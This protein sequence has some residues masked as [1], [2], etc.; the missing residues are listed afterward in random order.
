MT[1]RLACCALTLAL[2]LPST[3]AAQGPDLRVT[4]VNL[5]FERIDSEAGLSHNTVLSILQD[6]EGFL[7]I[8][9]SDGLNRYDGHAFVTYRHDPFDTTSLSNNTVKVLIE[10]QTGTLWAGTDDGLNRFD[11]RTGRFVRYRF[12]PDTLT[13]SDKGIK[14][15]LED[16]AGRLWVGAFIPGH[17]LN[18]YDPHTDQTR[19]FN[20]SPIW[21]LHEDREGTLW[22]NG[23]SAIYKYD[24]AADQMLRVQLPS[25]SGLD[26]LYED[27]QGRLWIQER[28]TGGVGVFDPQTGR[29]TTHALLPGKEPITY[30]LDDRNG[31]QWIGTNVGL[32]QRD[33][34]T[35]QLRY[36]PLD[37]SPQASLQNHITTLYEDRAG[38]V[39]VGTLSGLYRFDPHLKPFHHMGHD[40][41][42]SG[43]LSHSTVMA[44]WEDD[45]GA[46]WVGTLGGGLNRV[47][48]QTGTVTRY[49]HTAGDPG[50]LCSDRIWS[51]YGDHRG[52][53]WIGADGGLCALDRH[54]NR[55]TGYG[56]PPAQRWIQ[57]VQ[58]V[59]EDHAGRLW[60]AT[61]RGLFQLD[62]ET[63]VWSSRMDNP[64]EP[65]CCFIQSLHI[66]R[67]D[68]LWFG[69][70]GG[71]LFRFD[72]ETRTRTQHPL[73]IA[74]GQELVS[75]GLW[76][77]HEDSTGTL[78]IGSDQGLTRFDPEGSGPAP[79]TGVR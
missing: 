63:G 34:A 36:L 6:Q 54:T 16:Q 5:R 49:R 43:S 79:R 17:K 71:N 23:A 57:A 68:A 66:D 25:T 76:A 61:D 22:A 19:T 3:L 28:E 64:S 40:P 55:F 18:V 2:G 48:R 50:S 11:R 10:D 62:G 51:L 69:T 14:A 9:T 42:A 38:A 58:A 70:M 44:V 35:N 53:L 60:V 52:R 56:L 45:E 37:P 26:F 72:P 73:R 41:L 33:P 4:D 12:G 27:E 75:E 30:I 15:L 32:Y 74:D 20:T 24:P 65:S 78:W 7:W 47:D 21:S 31:L 29:T 46:V 8:G 39:W 1:L 13:V 67:A 59:R 77:L